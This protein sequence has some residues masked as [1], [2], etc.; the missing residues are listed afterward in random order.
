M[1]VP[2]RGISW[3]VTLSD[4]IYVWSVLH[5][6][7]ETLLLRPPFH[8]HVTYG[9][10]NLTPLV[11]F[12]RPQTNQ[13]PRPKPKAQYTI[14][15]P[16]PYNSY[17]WWNRII[18]EQNHNSIKTFCIAC[19]KH[20][21]FR[22]VSFICILPSMQKFPFSQVGIYGLSFFNNWCCCWRTFWTNL[23]SIIFL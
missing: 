19:L 22:I 5:L 1:H 12:I 14:L 10:L 9:T 23:L 11:L 13:R 16:Y 2:L 7:K 6:S 8:L 15:G 17:Q 20:F 18:T 4:R 3:K 21:A